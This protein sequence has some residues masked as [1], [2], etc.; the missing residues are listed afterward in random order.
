MIDRLNQSSE[1]LAQVVDT[2][3]LIMEGA[4]IELIIMDC[5]SC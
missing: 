4:E 3:E 2:N 5:D 1:G